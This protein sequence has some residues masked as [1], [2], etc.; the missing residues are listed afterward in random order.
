MQILA[1][2]RD[3]GVAD[4]VDYAQ[5]PWRS[6]RVDWCGQGV[7]MLEPLVEPIRANIL[8]SDRLHTDDTCV[9]APSDASFS[10]DKSGHVVR[11]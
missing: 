2:F 3:L 11:C 10:L 1:R 7:R 4:E 9:D 6:T 8:A 5:I